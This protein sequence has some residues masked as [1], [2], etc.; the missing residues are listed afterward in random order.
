MNYREKQ[1][2]ARLK[3]WGLSKNKKLEGGKANL[4]RGSLGAGTH[5]ETNN[6][7]DGYLLPYSLDGF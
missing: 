3:Q 5:T 7:G 6:E 1:L 4:D 2:K